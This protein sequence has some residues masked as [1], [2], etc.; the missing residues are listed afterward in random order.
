M[1]DCRTPHGALA[2]S[3][4]ASVPFTEFD[5]RRLGPVRRH[6]L[7][8]PRA[9]DWVVVAIYVVP[10]LFASKPGLVPSWLQIGL[11][12]AIGVVLL[13]RRQQPILVAASV[14]TLAVIVVVTTGSTANAE[15]ALA[16]A[17]YCVAA[18]YPP[19]ATWLTVF[20][21]LSAYAGSV[22]LWQRTLTR[23]SI[24]FSTT[25]TGA[26]AEPGPVGEKLAAI[27]G[28]VLFTLIAVSI[29]FSV[30]S[31]RIH[32][33]DLVERANILA[34]ERDQEGQIAAARERARIARE[35]HD[36]VA[37]S[38]TVMITLADG[39][40]ATP[41][42]ALAGHALEELS[43]TGRS[44]LTDMR[45]VLGVLR[46]DDEVPLTPGD[47]G[48]SLDELVEPFRTA[49]LKVR[50]VRSGRVTPLPADLRHAAQRIVTEA[51]TNVLRHAPLAASTE[52]HVSERREEGTWLD[53]RIVN[54]AGPVDHPHQSIFGNGHGIIG[55][56]ERAAMYDGTATAGPTATGWEVRAHLRFPD[57]AVQGEPW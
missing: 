27:V 56:K 7:R 14:A 49:G 44:A 47:H 41:D 19:T 4:V 42:R 5:A 45:R 22:L 12:L 16:F 1:P 26:L 6:F 50:I 20:G 25:N 34:R 13:A 11:T 46:E 8:H 48:K 24:T 57:D 23:A 39:A 55:M 54:T 18:A 37:H 21:V 9:M 35:M 33:A 38:L 15:M 53:L 30:R 52:V 10:S 51:L 31:R 36:V 40:R 32:V 43:A 3:T 2:T 28:T 17:C 29:G